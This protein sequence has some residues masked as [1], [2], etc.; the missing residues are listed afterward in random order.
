VRDGADHNTPMDS[1]DDARFQQGLDWLFD[2]TSAR[3]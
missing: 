2:H 1:A 3:E